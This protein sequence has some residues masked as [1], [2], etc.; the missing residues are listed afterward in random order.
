MGK[1]ELWGNPL[2]V[3]RSGRERRSGKELQYLPTRATIARDSTLPFREES[4]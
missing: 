1:G 2:A 4:W 3:E